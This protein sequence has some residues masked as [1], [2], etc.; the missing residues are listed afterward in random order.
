MHSITENALG[1]PLVLIDRPPL[2]LEF[3]VEVIDTA[4]ASVGTRVTGLADG[5]IIRSGPG[6]EFAGISRARP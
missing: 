6:S 2:S 4:G 5:G 3:D 1:Q